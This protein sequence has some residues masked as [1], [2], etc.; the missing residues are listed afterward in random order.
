MNKKHILA[1]AL[2][3]LA[4]AGAASANENEDKD[5]GDG[6]RIDNKVKLMAEIKG[7][8]RD[9]RRPELVGKVTSVNGTT[10]TV[11]GKNFGSGSAS[12]TFTVDASSAVILKGGATTTVSGIA[13]GDVVLVQGTLSGSTITAKLIHSGVR[14]GDDKPKPKEDRPGIL[15][16]GQ[17]VIAGKVTA[18]SGT[19][20]T[21]QSSAS[22]TYSVNAANAVIKTKGN[23]SST[24]SAITVG[25]NVVVQGTVN[26][27]SVVA[28]TIIE[29]D[30]RMDNGGKGNGGNKGFFG[31]IGSFFRSFFRF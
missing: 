21:V 20:I 3:T 17:P 22:S 25:D 28:S 24:I 29:Q 1:L 13:V 30:A 11:T 10:L 23:V 27:S 8:L 15:N 12:S 19:M 26:G 5:R 18:V 9:M 7:D 4:I 6:F 31:R 14:N 16:N 2:A